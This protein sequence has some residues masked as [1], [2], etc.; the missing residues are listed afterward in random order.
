MIGVNEIVTAVL[1]IAVIVFVVLVFAQ[2]RRKQSQTDVTF[3][4]ALP[5]R[6]LNVSAGE[7]QATPIAEVIEETVRTKAAQD[8]ALAGL[9]VDFGTAADGSL[10]IW[11]DSQLYTSIEEVPIA[12]LRTAIQEAVEEYNQAM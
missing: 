7:E 1:L 9:N 3:S 5:D 10:E 8:P 4:E 12:P 2:Q 6:D 11:V